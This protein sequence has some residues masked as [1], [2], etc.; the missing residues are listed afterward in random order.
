MIPETLMDD[1]RYWE[2]EALEA[3]MDLLRYKLRDEAAGA[4]EAA[5]SLIYA[6]KKM[7]EV[8]REIRRQVN[9]FKKANESKT[10]CWTSVN[11]QKVGVYV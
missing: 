4:D 3:R 9:Q 10:A 2:C 11:G 1:L 5:T 8:K 7:V 6:Q